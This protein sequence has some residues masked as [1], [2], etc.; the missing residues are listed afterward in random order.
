MAK[1]VGYFLQE[2]LLLKSS[3]PEPFIF[4]RRYLNI[5]KGDHQMTLESSYGSELFVGTTQI[6][7]SQKVWNFLE[8]EQFRL[9]VKSPEKRH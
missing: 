4:L 8:T 9:S 2:T 6:G 5:W 7:V 1:K 3:S